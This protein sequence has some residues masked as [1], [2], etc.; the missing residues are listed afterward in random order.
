MDKGEPKKP[1]YKRWWVWLI[2]MLFVMVVIGSI[3]GGSGDK[4][5]EDGTP[6]TSAESSENA[7]E[8][9]SEEEN[10]DS[11]EEESSVSS[12][13]PDDKSRDELKTAISTPMNK[14]SYLNI[15]NGVLEAANYD[16]QKDPNNSGAKKRFD[17]RT[18][19]LKQISKDA[20]AEVSKEKKWLTNSDYEKLVDYTNK[21]T[22]Y[23]D[24]LNN[25]AVTFQ[26]DTPSINNPNTSSDL[27]SSLQAEID[28]AKSDYLSKKV[29][30]SDAF[31][32]I[33]NS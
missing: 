2:V 22:D 16:D 4:S 25:Y 7:A 17:S 23:L 1:I 15:E 18:E 12:S 20:E 29:A 5:S 6:E 33:E 21:L 27:A 13:I 8:D 26:T 14:E 28:S 24:S 32:S 9:D 3:T 30:W 31:D 10:S 11:Y 19:N